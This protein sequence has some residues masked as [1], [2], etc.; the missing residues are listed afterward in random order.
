ML[1]ASKVRTMRQLQLQQ[2]HTPN[3]CL[4]RPC[5]ERP[6]LLQDRRRHRPNSLVGGSAS[7]RMADGEAAAADN[8]VL[9]RFLL[10]DTFYK[11][12]GF[13][14]KLPSVFF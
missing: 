12:I 14:C 11:I 6:F 4:S 2:P 7:C 10:C 5:L 1:V 8:D 9:C 13:L 3:A